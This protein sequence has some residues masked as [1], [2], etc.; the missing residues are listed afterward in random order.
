MSDCRLPKVLAFAAIALAWSL[1][2]QG[3]TLC[4]RGSCLAQDEGGASEEPIQLLQ[5]ES[6]KKP[7]KGSLSQEE[8]KRPAPAKFGQGPGREPPAAA[9]EAQKHPSVAVEAVQV[10]EAAHVNT[11]GTTCTKMTGGTCAMSGICDDTRSAVCTNGMCMCPQYTCASEGKCSISPAEVQKGLSNNA[12]S[13]VAS[14]TESAAKIPG[15][16]DTAGAV[17]GMYNTMSGVMGSIFGTSGCSGYVGVCWGSCSNQQELGFTA[18]CS[19][20]SCQCQ[21]GFCSQNGKCEFDVSGMLG[22]AMQSMTR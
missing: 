7:G 18:S 16:A 22:G 6:S 13:V 5:V 3:D 19:Y 2:P 4:H 20:G 21:S 10:R 12:N 14:V 11:S 9:V 15:L 1:D 17:Q 8:A